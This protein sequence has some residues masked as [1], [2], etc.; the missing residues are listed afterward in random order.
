[1]DSVRAVLPD[2]RDRAISTLTLAFA[3]DP[4]V[5]WAFSDPHV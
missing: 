3:S 1:M 2:E 4:I 5:R